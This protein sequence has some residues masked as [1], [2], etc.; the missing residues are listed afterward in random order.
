M[1]VICPQNL[2]K[3]LVGTGEVS[4]VFINRF[5][6]FWAAFSRAGGMDTSMDA[7]FQMSPR[8]LKIL[9]G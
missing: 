7:V 1:D 5:A 8:H 6:T 9:L 2:A 4:A 3:S